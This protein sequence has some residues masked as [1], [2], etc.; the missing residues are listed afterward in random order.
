M[1]EHISAPVRLFLMVL[2]VV[3]FFIAAFGWPAPVEPYRL[4]I[5]AGG[6]FCWA[7]ATFF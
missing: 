4:K 6:L 7:L 3:L 5:V 1:N 2:A